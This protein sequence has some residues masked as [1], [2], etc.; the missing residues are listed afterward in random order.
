MFL[1]LY[2][3]SFKLF[4]STYDLYL[5]FML[6]L[7]FSQLCSETASKDIVFIKYE[8]L[9]YCKYVSIAGSYYMVISR[10]NMTIWTRIW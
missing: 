5:Q 7:V 4:M 9:T 6:K 1:N 10:A 8:N 2:L 3:I